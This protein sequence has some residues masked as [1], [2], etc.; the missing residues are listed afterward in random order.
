MKPPRLAERIVQLSLRRDP[1]ERDAV[2]GDLAEEFGDLA[3][4]R[5]RWAAATWYWSQAA[6][7]CAPNVRRR[8]TRRRH[9]FAG[10]GADFRIAA[11]GL[12]RRPG[13][14]VAAILTVA[15]GVGSATAVF[16]VVD[17][18]V[19]RAL[20]LPEQDRVVVVSGVFDRFPGRMFQISNAEF[21]D[22][23][24]DL[25]SA[26]AL[27]AWFAT[28]ELLPPRRGGTART[29]D[30]AY[31][32][33]D[34]YT[35]VGARVVLGRLPDRSDDRLTA[36]RVAVI[37]F[38]L[39]RDA[40]GRDASVIGT[41]AVTV[42]T[43]PVEIIGVLAPETR[44]PAAAADIWVHTVLNPASWAAN[45]SGHGL[46][47]IAAL[48]PDATVATARAELTA[49]HSE[50]ARR[51]AGQHSFGLEGHAARVDL[52]ADRLL[53]T[54]RRVAL[55]LSV[56]AGLLLALACA[57]VAN[58]LLA[59]GE[60]RTSEV[61]VRIALGASS[62]RVAQ[63]VLFESLTIAIAGGVGGLVLAAI[64]LPPLLRLAPEAVA[65]TAD[66]R[67]DARVAAFA[68][69]VSLLSGIAV[70]AVPAWRATRR[71]PSEL[72]R[73]SGRG[74]SASMNG[75][76]VLVAGQAALATGLLIGAML[77][78]GSL[79]RLNAVRPG[80][81]ASARVA[82]DLTLPVTGYQSADAIITFYERLQ[83]RLNALPGVASASAVRML[84]LRDT[85]RNETVIR[86]GASDPQDRLGIAVQAASAGV[87]RTLGIA[88]IDGRDFAPSDR[89]G[90]PRVALVNRAA[91]R[92]LWPAASAT[93]RRFRATFLPAT[94][95]ITV[96]GVYE[97]VRSA[98]L[99]S[100]P[101]PEIML[102]IGQADGLGG[103]IRSVT[104]VVHAEHTAT[105][106]AAAQ[107]VVRELDPAVAVESPTTMEDVLRASTARERFLAT[108]LAVFS[109]LALMIAAVGVFGVVSFSVTRRARDIAI[110]SAL[111]AGNRRI[112]S[113]VLTA[114]AGVAAAGAAIGA[115]AAAWSAPAVA[116]LLHDIRP[117]DPAILL[118][119]PVALVAVAIAA[120]LVPALR[121]ARV[122]AARALQ[123]AD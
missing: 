116:A 17:A 58:L 53:G 48:R 9:F 86:E 70:A 87:L 82:V 51:H 5:G 39:W 69:A 101:A 63:P 76:N 11:R 56:A 66:V 45:R 79:N 18:T 102:P 68:L 32:Y 120:S 108:L 40:F 4:T 112:L 22:L 27:G 99:S 13:F 2:L 92:A 28:Q 16:S 111:G 41:H 117:R 6:R 19:L 64:A 21:A 93:G 8:L 94:G 90:A 7:S 46:T 78:A 29:I 35:L 89:L 59:R 10:A 33:G 75:L 118:S 83:Q 109:V 36:P 119:A 25:R 42:G 1:R 55:L 52:I 97:D 38:E 105:T 106:L 88:L 95:F 80:L 67:T 85:P 31:T 14:A 91:A 72:L 113:S 115:A 37:A 34:V 26:S 98:G 47:V 100:A 57:N 54:S 60:A 20:G 49:L 71:M 74:R 50:W 65:A 104:A 30:A 61:G 15:M 77:F 3:A 107:S 121:A 81:D 96:V 24:Q 44:L 114:S 122:P 62:G 123:D 23:R 84:P 43:Q 110:R 103:W 12:A 73:A